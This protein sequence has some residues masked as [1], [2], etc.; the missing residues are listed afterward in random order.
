MFGLFL[1]LNFASL[2]AFVVGLINPKLVLRGDNR[3]RRKSSEI[4]LSAF[5]LSF[6]GMAVFVPKP[7]PAVV[8]V[9]PARSPKLEVKSTPTQEAKPLPA[10][11]PKQEVK[12]LPS[13]T[14][15]QAES[16]SDGSRRSSQTL[17]QASNLYKTEVTPTPTVTQTPAFIAFD[18]SVCD[19][20]NYLPVNG[21]SI[22]L[23]TTCQYIKTDSIKPESVSVVTGVNGDRDPSVLE[24]EA[25]S[26]FESVAWRDYTLAP[27]HRKDVCVHYKD[28]SVS[29]LTFSNPDKMADV[30]IQPQA[31]NIPAGSKCEDFA[32]QE[33]VQAALPSNPQL[34]GDGDGTACDSL[35]SG[36][37]SQVHQNSSGS[38]HHTGRRRRRR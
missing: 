33:Q 1:L 34:D 6:I 7:E 32:T 19:T 5:V 28:K 16:L 17:P 24:L 37:G 14:P 8:A 38:Y 12:S 30:Q 13:P 22:A 26:G 3:T 15:T 25:E 4:Y 10:Q 31:T 18:K 11:T 23:Y 29:C 27:E 2:I 9:K 20:D 21:A 35:A 36:G